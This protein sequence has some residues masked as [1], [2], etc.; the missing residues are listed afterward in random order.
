[1]LEFSKVTSDIIK[2]IKNGAWHKKCVGKYCM[3][4]NCSVLRFIEDQYTKR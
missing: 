1:M 3:S 4:V 2:A